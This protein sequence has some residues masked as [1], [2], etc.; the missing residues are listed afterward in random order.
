MSKM[1]GL[2]HK[3]GWHLTEGE[4]ILKGRLFRIQKYI[5]YTSLKLKSCVLQL[6][7]KLF[8]SLNWRNP[9][10]LSLCNLYK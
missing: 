3:A 10:A 8:A 2:S 4:I 5:L 7:Q 6:F 1:Y 9:S